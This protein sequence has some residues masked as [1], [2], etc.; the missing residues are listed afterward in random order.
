MKA[1]I[2]AAGRGTRTKLGI[3]KPLVKIAGLSLLER[4]ILNFISLNIREIVIVVGHQA[5]KIKN[6]LKNKKIT[7]NCQIIWVENPQ[8]Q[9]GNGLSVLYARDYVEEHFLLS[10]VDHLYE[11]KL[12]SSLLSQLDDLIC[13][14]DS[15][16]KFAD[17]QDATRVL[18]EDGRVRKI[19]KNL[20]QYNALD[21]GLFLCSRKIFPV[22][23]ETIEEGREE[24]DSTKNKFAQRFTAK[25]FDICGGFWMD[26]DTPEDIARARRLLKGKKIEIK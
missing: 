4:T 19:G 18:I 1:V 15:Q 17:P 13:V 25:T 12:F 22:L 24:W 6:Y 8:F 20:N 9:R 14:V 7:Q 26:V 16:P 21:C 10:M 2:L 23:A 3:P 5:K 11:A